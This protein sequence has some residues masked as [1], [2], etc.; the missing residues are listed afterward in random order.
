MMNS[1]VLPQMVLAEEIHHS[2]ADA[3]DIEEVHEP[4]IPVRDVFWNLVRHPRQMITRWNWKSA[5]IGAIV[6]ASF[7]FTVYQ[8]S[9]ESLLVTLTAVLVE[10]SFR[11]FTTGVSGS[12]VQSFR[13]ATPAWLANIIVSV[14]LP[15]F[16][17]TIEFLSHY[18]QENYFSTIFAASENKARQRAF[19]ISVLISVLSALFNLHVMRHGVLLV[20]AGKETLSLWGDLKRIPW[21]LKEF[22]VF[23]PDLILK[24]FERG[25][26]LNA[27]GVFCA[28]GLAVGT[29]LGGARFS[30]QW[31]WTTALGSW[32]FLL[33]T[34]IVGAIVRRI[35][36]LS[37]R[38]LPVDPAGNTNA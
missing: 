29:I 1:E 36:G 20:G 4:E 35:R 3:D 32:T 9:R 2:I 26:V 11:F 8:A 5:L 18:A 23:L 37:E 10:L 33:V 13:H 34:I 31:A 25:Q 24:N 6:R 27:V 38:D 12:I 30:W 19:A 17:H 21:L 16:S 22:V 28:F 15:V 14:S 7:Y